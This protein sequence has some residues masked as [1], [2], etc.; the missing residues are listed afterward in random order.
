VGSLVAL[1]EGA[2]VLAGAAAFPALGTSL[3]A[4]PGLGCWNGD[5][6][7]RV[8]EV[9]ALREATVLLTDARTLVAG[10]RA[11][12]LPRL[13][14]EARMVR[15]WGDCVGYLLVATGRAEVMIDVVMQPWDAAPLQPIIEE[16]GGVFTDLNGCATAFGDGVIATNR[17]LANDAR[18]V[19]GIRI[20]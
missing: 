1:C 4:A 17:A 8:S 2:R 14:R 6:R 20:V 5:S 12:G 11:D 7:A 19:M 3:F 16:A 9:G 18:R 13:A 10:P 15:T